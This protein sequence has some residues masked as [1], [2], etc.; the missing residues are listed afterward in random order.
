MPQTS[1]DEIELSNAEREKL[2]SLARKYTAPYKELGPTW[3]RGMSDA[4]N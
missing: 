4:Q 1:P 2:E 3:R